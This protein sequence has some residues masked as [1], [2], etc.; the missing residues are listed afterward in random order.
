MHQALTSK[1]VQERRIEYNRSC[2]DMRICQTRVLELVEVLKMLKD[3]VG[4]GSLDGIL[5]T[6][7]VLLV[8]NL[9]EVC[10][11][12]FLDSWFY[13]CRSLGHERRVIDES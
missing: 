6:S 7:R 13:H 3:P 9:E 10:T 11:L 12:W 1:H 5:T 8:A 2:R 4:R